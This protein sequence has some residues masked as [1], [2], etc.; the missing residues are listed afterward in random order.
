MLT[1]LCG[2]SRKARI[3]FAFAGGSGTVTLAYYHHSDK[4]GKVEYVR[5]P[6]TEGKGGVELPVGKP[7]VVV[8]GNDRQNTVCPVYVSGGEDIK[9]SGPDNKPAEWIVEGDEENELMS[10]WR[11]ANSRL[12]S[13]GPSRELNAK[14]AEFAKKHPESQSAGILLVLYYDRREDQTEFEKLWNSLAPDIR[15]SEIVTA[16]GSAGKWQN[17][18]ASKAGITAAEFYTSADSIVRIDPKDSPYNIYYFREEKSNDGLLT[19]LAELSDSTSGLRLIDVMM[20]PDSTGWRRSV[21]AG[22]IAVWTPG[23]E[24]N[25]AVKQFGLPTSPFIILVDSAG[26]QLYRGKDMQEMRKRIKSGDF[27]KRQTL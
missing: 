1:L 11:L 6:Y 10:E 24:E 16:L 9:V 12:L 5:I 8:L 13:H 4:K 27:N 26:R 14:I 15:A 21:K 23:G 19:S 22:S 25:S 3:E 20:R 2:C 17:P 7:A 18:G